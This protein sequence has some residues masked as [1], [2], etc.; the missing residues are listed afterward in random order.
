YFG[1]PYSDYDQN[2]FGV[3]PGLIIGSILLLLGFF[4]LY[5]P[6]AKSLSIVAETPITSRRKTIA[7][8]G[9]FLGSVLLVWGIWG[10]VPTTFVIGY[11]M[12][13]SDNSYI[14]ALLGFALSALSGIFIILATTTGSFGLSYAKSKK[15]IAWRVATVL[16]MFIFLFGTM[17]LQPRT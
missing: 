2:Y 15:E 5:I 14:Y 12:E 7:T 4:M 16:A 6:W 1:E 3:N 9:V 8:I 10:W 11:F 17:F 13:R